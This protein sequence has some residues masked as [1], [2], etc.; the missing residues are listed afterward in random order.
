MTHPLL[1]IIIPVYNGEG[2]IT[3]CIDSIYNQGL[4]PDEFEVICVDDCST[5]A[6]PRV[7]HELAALRPNLTVLRHNVNKRQGGGETQVSGRRKAATS[8]TLTATTISC[9]VRCPSWPPN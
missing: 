2:F 3:K 8:S 4:A 6:T 1:S 5:D 9:P 7:L